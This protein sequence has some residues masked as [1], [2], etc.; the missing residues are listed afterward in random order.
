MWGLERAFALHEA[1][2]SKQKTA[3][4]KYYQTS[5]F[6][7][8]VCFKLQNHNTYCLVPGRMPLYPA[9]EHCLASSCAVYK[10]KTT[11]RIGTAT[12]GKEM[13]QALFG[14]Y[15]EWQI[16][17]RQFKCE[18]HKSTPRLVTP[19]MPVVVLLLLTSLKQPP[20]P[21]SNLSFASHDLTASPLLTKTVFGTL[22]PLLKT[23]EL[24]N[25]TQG[26]YCIGRPHEYLTRW[27]IL[28]ILKKKSHYTFD[29]A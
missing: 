22:F 27:V 1:K 13:L 7:V 2:S 29:T 4:Q 12:W 8:T 18:D 11:V 16:E 15:L 21:E 3:Y 10:N 24:S 17:A 26:A 20:V 9:S 5:P 19:H 6:V 28:F 14:C 25:P 23:R